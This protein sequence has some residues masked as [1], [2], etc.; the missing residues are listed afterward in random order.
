MLHA[1]CLSAWCQKLIW[2]LNN[3]MFRLRGEVAHIRSNWQS[4][5]M[6]GPCIIRMSCTCFRC[7]VLCKHSLCSVC[8][9]IRLSRSYILSIRTNISS[10]IFHCLVV[11]PFL[12][13]HTKCHGDIQTGSPLTGASNAGGVG[14]NRDSEPISDFIM[15]CKCYVHLQVL[16]TRCRRTVAGC[17]TYCWW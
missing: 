8:P 4:K 9:S 7:A 2:K 16:S 1:F 3:T 15:C 6:E 5:L 12:F 13:F 11:I 10:K 14:R 17:D